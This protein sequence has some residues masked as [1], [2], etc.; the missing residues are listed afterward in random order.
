M[1]QTK[2][3][4]EVITQERKL[5]EVEVEQITLMTS[6]GEVTILPGHMN[7]FSRL[8]PG[9]LQYKEK[10]VTHYL[11][12]YGGFMDIS[13]S[14][15]VSILADAAERAEDIDLERVEA[16]KAKAEK[17]LEGQFETP[18]DF[19][20]AETALRQIYLRQKVARLHRSGT[21]RKP[22]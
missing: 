9:V 7:L 12:V 17:T 22:V 13:A 16:A 10:G 3:R 15:R 8:A 14:D 4:L 21:G 1:S 2:L 20:M 6:T 19:T 18:Q 11:A 5:L